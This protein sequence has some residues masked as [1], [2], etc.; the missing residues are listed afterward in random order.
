MTAPCIPGLFDNPSTSQTNAEKDKA[1]NPVKAE[2]DRL[3]ATARRLLVFLQERQG[4]WI[5]NAVLLSEGGFRYGGRLYEIKHDGWLIEKRHIE[6]GCW[7]YRLTG[8][9]E[10]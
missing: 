2:K 1:A 8:R 10:W 6:G 9:K 7:Q 4:Q 5:D 3:N